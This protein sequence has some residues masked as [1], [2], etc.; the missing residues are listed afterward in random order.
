MELSAARADRWRLVV[1]ALAVLGTEPHS[2]SSYGARGRAN[3]PFPIKYPLNILPWA[4]GVADPDLACF[5]QNSTL[6]TSDST[7]IV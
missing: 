2:V 7:A 5:P 6:T 4:A 3:L 1:E